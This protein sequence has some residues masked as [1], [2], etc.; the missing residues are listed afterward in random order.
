MLGEH[1]KIK[2]SDQLNKEENLIIIGDGQI[3]KQTDKNDALDK[4]K[5]C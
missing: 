2:L 5:H 4:K 1:K 3:Q